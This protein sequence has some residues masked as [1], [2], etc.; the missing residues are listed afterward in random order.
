MCKAF[1]DHYESGRK[2]GF[3]QG[4]SEGISQERETLLLALIKD[5]E[6]T[7]ESAARRMDMTPEEFAAKYSSKL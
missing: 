6:I 7:I 3:N 4:I 1:E 5:K 2:F